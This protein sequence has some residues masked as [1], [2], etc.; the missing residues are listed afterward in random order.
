[1]ATFTL[2]GL[3]RITPNINSIV[4]AARYHNYSWLVNS[5]NKFIDDIY[6][7]SFKDLGLLE[8][9]VSGKYSGKELLKIH[10]NDQSPYLEFYL[11]EVGTAI[12]SKDEAIATRL[13]RICFFLHS[14][15]VSKPLLIDKK[16]IQLHEMNEL[17]NRL[18]PFAHYIP[19]D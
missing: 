17:P 18:L 9:L 5:D 13:F 6:W 1:M 14:V 8:F 3:Y 10:Q 16:E 2:I 4:S 15:D 19:V 12:I 11:N 7:D